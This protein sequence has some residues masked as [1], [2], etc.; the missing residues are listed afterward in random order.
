MDGKDIDTKTNFC[1]MIIKED[2]AT[3]REKASGSVWVREGER[4]RD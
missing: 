2:M 3:G 1:Q 4:K